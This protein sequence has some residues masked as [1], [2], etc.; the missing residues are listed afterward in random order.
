MLEFWWW[1][2]TMQAGCYLPQSCMLISGPQISQLLG[3]RD[4]LNACEHTREYDIVSGIWFP[5]QLRLTIFTAPYILPPGHWSGAVEVAYTFAAKLV[6]LQGLWKQV[7]GPDCSVLPSGAVFVR[8][9]QS[10]R[11]CWVLK[12]S[13]QG[14][15]HLGEKKSYI[16][17]I[18]PIG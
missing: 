16:A 11:Y 6:L 3:S 2:L 10:E 8:V 1:F 12:F 9:T 7:S 5:L 13:S 17:A 18:N 14:A 4:V 15:W